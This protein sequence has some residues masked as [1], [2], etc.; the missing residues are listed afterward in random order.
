MFYQLHSFKLLMSKLDYG[1]S[2]PKIS[3][4]LIQRQKSATARWAGLPPTGAYNWIVKIYKIDNF[5]EVFNN[6]WITGI[7]SLIHKFHLSPFLL[8]IFVLVYLD[9]FCHSFVNWVRLV[10]LT[11]EAEKPVFADSELLRQ[12]FM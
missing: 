3:P 10:L 8:S 9:N 7:F 4:F 12:H 11:F 5:F 2:S 6:E 1:P